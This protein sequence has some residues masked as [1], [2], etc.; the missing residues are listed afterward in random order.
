MV[1][2]HWRAEKDLAALLDV[3]PEDPRF[4]VVVVDNSGGAELPPASRAKLVRPF[5]NLGFGGGA[6]LGASVAAAPLLLVANPDVRP[7]AGALTSL[8]D[9]FHALPEA[10]GLAPRLL[11]ADGT[12]QTAWQLRDLP[13]PAQLLQHGL[14]RDAGRGAAGEPA[15][16]SPIAQPAA[17]A[18]AL[19]R[20]AWERL[21]GFDST[22]HPAWF[23]DVDLAR[24]LA[25]AGGTIAYW[26]A[27]AFR[28]GLGGSVAPLGYGA[29]LWHYHR[30]LGRYLRKH[31]GP[32]S[33]TAARVVL[34]V[35]A[36]LRALVLP[37]RRPRRARSRG[38]ALG[39]LA[40]VG[41]GALTNWR[42]PRRLAH[43]ERSQ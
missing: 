25:A 3:V 12:P 9:G 13:R 16:G 10:A 29:F 31:H 4:E 37:L 40:V 27:A 38:E 42:R 17:A 23:E 14:F 39:G 28:H 19:R 15:A 22:F 5:A 34:V 32:A 30:N 2:V 41:L 1:V 18:L 7:E 24:R 33:A 26:P 43:V 8:I 35:G 36:A 11:G 6:N 21:G 20:S